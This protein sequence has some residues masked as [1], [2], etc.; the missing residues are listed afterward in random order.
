[1]VLPLSRTEP[2][3]TDGVCK[4]EVGE[5]VNIDEQIRRLDKLWVREEDSVPMEEKVRIS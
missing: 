5:A 4:I 2:T 3:S 1:M